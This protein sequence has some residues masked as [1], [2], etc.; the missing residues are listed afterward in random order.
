MRPKYGIVENYIAWDTFWLQQEMQQKNEW[1]I[2]AEGTSTKKP[3]E[4]CGVQQPTLR[5]I[6]ECN[7]A[8]QHLY[9]ASVVAA[10]YDRGVNCKDSGRPHSPVLDRLKRK[11]LLLGGCVA[12]PPRI[13]VNPFECGCFVP[14]QRGPVNRETSCKVQRLHNHLFF[15]HKAPP[16][17]ATTNVLISIV[18]NKRVFSSIPEVENIGMTPKIGAVCTRLEVD[19]HSEPSIVVVVELPNLGN[20][21]GLLV[22]MCLVSQ[23][24]SSNIVHHP[25]ICRL[26]IVADSGTKRGVS[27]ESGNMLAS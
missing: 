13:E 2:V 15:L 16:E 20:D 18:D 14:L 22:G 23:G 11:V 12:R 21:I 10:T 1:P 7:L 5:N 25:C 9:V 4:Y 26:V 3:C 24:C 8:C 19:G 17:A 27:A 6:D